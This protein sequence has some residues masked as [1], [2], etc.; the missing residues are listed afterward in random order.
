MYTNGPRT[1]TNP[2]LTEYQKKIESMDNVILCVSEAEHMIDAIGR[3]MIQDFPQIERISPR[4]KAKKP[5]W[6]DRR[7]IFKK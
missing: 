6:A 7:N 5:P 4:R 1:R 3:D 2:E